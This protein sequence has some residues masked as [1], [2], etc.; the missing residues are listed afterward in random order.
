[1]YLRTHDCFLKNKNVGKEVIYPRSSAVIVNSHLYLNVLFCFLI[2]A[3]LKKTVNE[4][5]NRWW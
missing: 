5:L 4:S 3:G 2:A 1:M